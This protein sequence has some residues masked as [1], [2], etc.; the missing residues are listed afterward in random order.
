MNWTYKEGSM[1]LN[2]VLDSFIETIKSHQTAY[3][4]IIL[5]ILVGFTVIR[6]L[7]YL[8]ECNMSNRGIQ[9]EEVTK[10]LL[11]F[12]ILSG[13][14]KFCLTSGGLLDIIYEVFVKLGQG[15][16]GYSGT[17]S[18]ENIFVALF[19][20]FE[21]VM[22]SIKHG[23]DLGYYA[24]H[25]LEIND[26]RWVVPNTIFM[27][28][29]MGFLT[30]FTVKVAL[31]YFLAIIEFYL[32]GTIS[33]VFLVFHTFDFTKNITGKTTEII[34]ANGLRLSFI[35]I[36][37]HSCIGF[38]TPY[39]TTFDLSKNWLSMFEFIAILIVWYYILQEM[40]KMAQTV[41]NTEYNSTFSRGSVGKLA[42]DVSK[43]GGKQV[44]R[45]VGAVIG[46]AATGSVEG[47]K[48]GYEVGEAAGKYV[49][50]KS[51]EG[52]TYLMRDEGTGGASAEQQINKRTGANAD[53]LDKTEKT[54]EQELMKDAQKIGGSGGG[55]PGADGG[56]MPTPPPVAG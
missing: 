4:H 23:F 40:P 37:Y 48:K 11:T 43:E 7:W 36:I 34:L 31:A 21:K 25:P 13:I 1:G 47:A 16:S 19:S 6:L 32:L 29:G 8:L 10:I 14:I 41:I 28:I 12:V 51:A 30:Y 44:G 42:S 56:G 39:L 26:I 9:M 27:V 24:T 18:I 17:L 3:S 55:M 49:G 5:L 15:I 22:T 2:A 38:I 52:I 35:M 50:A 33:I 45:V 46:A 54:P 20:S 53:D